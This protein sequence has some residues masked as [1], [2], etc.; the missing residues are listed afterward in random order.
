MRVPCF[1]SNFAD[2]KPKRGLTSMVES[3][4][5]LNINKTKNYGI[6]N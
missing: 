1:F 2:E 6:F 5:I 3:K 4:N